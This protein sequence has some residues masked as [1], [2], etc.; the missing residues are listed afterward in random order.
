MSTIR[1]TAE[2]FSAHRFEDVFG[3]LADD[4]RWV[5]VGQTTVEGRDAIV[6][7]CRDAAEG[8][9]ASTTT[10]DRFRVVAGVDAVAVDVV[11]RYSDPTGRTSVVSSCDIYEF[12][13]EALR[14]ITSYAVEL[15]GA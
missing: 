15:G 3:H 5:L 7:L 4:A 13:G 2:A 1:D 10:F 6:A 12:D 14:T 8:F 9:A 11:A